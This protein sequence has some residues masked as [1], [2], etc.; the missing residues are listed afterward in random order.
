[1]MPLIRDLAR[2][3]DTLRRGMST[4][5]L[6]WLRSPEPAAAGLSCN[7]CHHGLGSAPLW[8]RSKFECRGG[9]GNSLGDIMTAV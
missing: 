5:F 3:L 9:R 6:C 2:R 1:M 4:A 7:R 8:P